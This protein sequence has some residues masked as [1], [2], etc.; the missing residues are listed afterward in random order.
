MNDRFPKTAA[1]HLPFP[2]AEGKPML[3]LRQATLALK[4]A[5]EHYLG[6]TQARF[7]MLLLLH[8]EGE[9]SQTEIQKRLSVDRSMITRLVKQME[10]DQL[11]FRRVDPADNRFTLVRLSD[12]GIALDDK[13]IDRIQELE[14]T[15]LRGIDKD[16][17]RQLQ[18]SLE[19]I[20]KNAEDILA[21]EKIQPSLAVDE[22]L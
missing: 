20:R 13:M 19:H 16:D 22:Y 2:N 14:N 12:M 10:T 8:A 11:L 18:T 7:T 15:L 17:L 5:F 6:I 4:P 3:L 9:L 21:E 1:P